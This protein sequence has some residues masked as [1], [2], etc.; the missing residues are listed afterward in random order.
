M[1]DAA[2]IINHW[3][4]KEGRLVLCFSA[5]FVLFASLLKSTDDEMQLKIQS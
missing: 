2:V 1:L 4:V 3:T 5:K